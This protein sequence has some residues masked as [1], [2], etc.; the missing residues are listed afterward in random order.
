MNVLRGTGKPIYYR[1]WFWVA[2]ILLIAGTFYL[3]SYFDWRG[4]YDLAHTDDY[5]LGLAAQLF[6]YQ[7]NRLEEQYK[8]DTYGGD[9]PEETLR[10]FVE[11]LEKRDYVLASKYFAPERQA[12]GLQDI[13]V[14]E[15]SSGMKRF[16][17]AYR[18]GTMKSGQSEA[19]GDY[20][21]EI[22]PKG[23][24]TPFHMQFAKNPF[25]NKWK[26]TEL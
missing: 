20:G 19:T 14:A 8:N 22:Y 23:D 13:E 2:F 7:A 15:G 10:L 4:D 17:L 11:A 26:I 6:K 1:W 18:N 9:T 21:I 5:A 25:T 12:G 3:K 24:A 16:I